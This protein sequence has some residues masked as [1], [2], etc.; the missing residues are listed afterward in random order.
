MDREDA[1]VVR[2]ALFI[3]E[4]AT[5]TLRIVPLDNEKISIQEPV[6]VELGHR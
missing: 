3:T 4:Y 2:G 1:F 6:S 5:T